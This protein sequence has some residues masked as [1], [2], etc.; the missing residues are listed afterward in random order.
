MW[1]RITRWVAGSDLT[2]MICFTYLCMALAWVFV[3][4]L[5]N[6]RLA[7]PV[8][9]ASYARASG[10]L[11]AVVSTLAIF[12]LYGRSEKRLRA[13]EQHYR[14]IVETTRDGICLLDRGGVITYANPRM[15]E[16]TTSEWD[17]IGRAWP[18]AGRRT[19]GTWPVSG[20]PD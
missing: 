7:L 10:V 18:L 19:W 20:S 2:A 3:A 17:P 13:R 14:T 16:R 8:D 9:Q 4:E 12:L 5:V 1:R 6:E 11:F 15:A